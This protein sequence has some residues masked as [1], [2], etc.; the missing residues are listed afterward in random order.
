[1][2]DNELTLP[3]TANEIPPDSRDDALLTIEALRRE[4][5]ETVGRIL[6]HIPQADPEVQE[7]L[8]KY[9]CIRYSGYLEQI[10]FQAISGHIREPLSPEMADFVTS[11]FKKAPNLNPGQFHELVARFGAESKRAFNLFL[12]QGLRRDQLKSLLELRNDVAHGRAYRGNASSLT[13]YQ[14]LVVDLDEWI[15]QRWINTSAASSTVT[16]PI[17]THAVSSTPLTG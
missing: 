2:T 13:G 4:L 9:I 16:Q 3:S 15:V 12:D 6:A 11:Y 8:R 7:D 1:M 17:A 10:V 5:E 14:Q